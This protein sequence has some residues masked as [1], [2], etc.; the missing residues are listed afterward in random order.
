MKKVMFTL[1]LFF[2][3]T[4][5]ALN[6]VY[7]V[8]DP[9]ISPNSEI[10]VFEYEGDLWKV[11]AEGGT[12]TRITG[13]EGRESNP[14]FSPDG[15]WIAFSG[16]VEDNSNIYIL[17]LKGGAIIQLT[18]NDASDIAESWSWDS[19]FIYFTS[20]RYNSSSAFKVSVN[21]GT[22]ERI[23][24]HYFNR[25]YNFVEH[26]QSGEYYFNESYEANRFASRK[27]YKGDYNPDIKS[28]NPSTK[29]FT[30]HTDYIGKD[31]MPAIDRNGKVYF[32]SDEYNDEYNLYTFESGNKKRLTDF[33]SSILHPKVS[34]DGAKVVFEKD[35]QI[36]IYDTKSG[37]SSAVNISLFDINTLSISKQYKV[38]GKITNFNISPDNKKIALVSRG[39]LFVSDIDGKFIKQLNTNPNERV[40]EVIWLK[41]NKT[42]LYNQTDKGYLNLFTIKADGSGGETQL[43]K[44]T[45]SN[46]EIQ[47]NS[48]R[49]KAL[50]FSGRNELMMLDLES[51]E[52][53]L[54]VEDELWA[55]YD[56]P[57]YFSPDD[58]FV[59]YTAYRGFEQ[60][61]FVY[62][63][64][65]KKTNHITKTGVTETSPFWSPDGKYI[66]FSTDRYNP[67]YPRGGKDFDIYRIA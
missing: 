52:S 55:V 34:A 27:R 20:N 24:D 53:E 51:F 10:I 47:V 21:G 16:R 43:T 42:I 38:S 30:M 5:F 1:I 58:K 3:Q 6:P 13:M 23:F 50:Y 14:V 40:S 15:N 44:E 37:T 33:T 12:A 31:M 4:S 25:I 35:Y 18:F 56:T 59:L 45:E 32:L 48:D 49:T 2:V 17:P 11:N 61:I 65:K 41:D 67:S 26:P 39:E 29:K 36:Y 8:S 60:D 19:Q 64:D 28:Y 9:A 62:D 46:K 63:I 22:P 57:A 66:Y 7:F 54:L